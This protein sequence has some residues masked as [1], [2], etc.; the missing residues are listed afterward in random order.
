MKIRLPLPKPVQ[1]S[2]QSPKK[3]AQLNQQLAVLSAQ[4]RRASAAADYQLA[5]E[6]V[7]QVIDLVPQHPVAYMDLAYT[8]LQLKRY[9]DAYAHYQHAIT[10]SNGSVDP[11]I[12]DGLCEVCFALNRAQDMQHFGRLAIERKQQQASQEPK[13]T[14]PQAAPERFLAENPNQNIISFSL[15]GDHPR[16]CETAVLNVIRAKELYPNWRC[17]FYVDDSVP[18]PILQR[19]SQHGAQLIKVTETQAQISG[20]FWR[21]LVMDDPQ[22]KHFLIR[23]ADSLISPRE[24]AAVQQWLDSDRWFHLMR[25]YYSHTELIL[26]GMW[27]GCTGV[28]HQVEALISDYIHSGRYLNTRVMDQHFL[29]YCIWPTLCQSVMTHDR[30]GF[31][32][33]AEAFP[34]DQKQDTPV[35]LTRHPHVGMNESS[36]VVNV[37]VPDSMARQIQWILYNNRKQIVC[38][39]R[40]TVDESG[41]IDLHLPELYAAQIRVKAWNLQIYPV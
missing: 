32:P 37:T 16:Y 12:Y 27:G 4:F 34:G 20:L 39:Y 1:K 2:A 6:L 10:L 24:V 21:F 25:D 22:V 30:Y 29:R 40:A 31:D 26:A 3:L 13:L 18:T 17:R 7:R 28:F 5:Y 15:F 14:L 23:D 35:T 36:A 8:E 38:Q 11:N 41:S 33:S 9:L 19:L